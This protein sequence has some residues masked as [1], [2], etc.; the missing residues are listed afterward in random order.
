MVW[1]ILAAAAAALVCAV[2]VW[3]LR[4]LMLTPVKPGKSTRQFVCLYVSGRETGL[5]NNV[6]G[7]LWLNDCGVLRCRIL[8][9]GREVDDETRFIARTLERE[10]SCITFI[11][12]GEESEWIRRMSL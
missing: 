1:K 5:E 9:I 8:I 12:N 7:L 10:H 11:E 6:E 3:A 2:L 4:E